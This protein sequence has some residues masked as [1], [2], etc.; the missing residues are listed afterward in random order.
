M[1]EIK[2]TLKRAGKAVLKTITAVLFPVIVVVCI[3]LVLISAFVYFITIDDGTYKEDD[4]SSTPYAASTFVNG[5]TINQDGTISTN[6]TAEDLWNKMLENGSRVDEYLDSSE[7][8]S[9]KL[10]KILIPNIVQFVVLI[11]LLF[12]GSM[13]VVPIIQDIFEQVGSTDRLP[14]YTIAFSNFLTSVQE[15]WFIPTA[16]IAGIIVAIALYIRLIISS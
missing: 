14:S 6:T 13:Y 3:V 15:N 16:I 12:F 2:E 9:K 10:K 8:L 11:I 4:W 5:T 1:E 7:D